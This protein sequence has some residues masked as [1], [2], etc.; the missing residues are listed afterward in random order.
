MP[1]LDTTVVVHDSVLG[2]ALFAAFGA[3]LLTWIGAWLLT[4]RT[5]GRARKARL[6][7]IGSELLGN[8][9]FV[10][11]ANDRRALASRISTAVW[12]KVGIDLSLDV[13]GGVWTELQ[14]AYSRADYAL[15]L[16]GKVL[17]STASAEEMSWLNDWAMNSVRRAQLGVAGELHLS[18]RLRP[19]L[20][21]LLS[22]IGKKPWRGSQ[23]FKSAEVATKVER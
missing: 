7:A 23:A 15:L 10:R 8:F 18:W 3:S 11:A 14:L 4:K 9:N 1:V 12:E 6:L 16:Q 2:L 17:D 13:A 20:K 5:E 21:A 22:R 19:R